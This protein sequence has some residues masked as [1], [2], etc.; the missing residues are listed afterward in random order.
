MWISSLL[1]LGALKSEY[2]ET[3]LLESFSKLVLVLLFYCLR[4]LA[5]FVRSQFPPP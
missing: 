4:M 1:C 3:E 2:K 5:S